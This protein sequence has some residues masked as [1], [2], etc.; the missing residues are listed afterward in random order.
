MTVAGLELTAPASGSSGEILSSDA[1][2]FVARLAAEFEP[3][4]QELLTLRRF[5]QAEIDAGRFPDFLEETAAM[6]AKDWTVA[7]IPRDLEDRRVEITGPV[8]RKMVINAL[9]SGANVFMADFEDANSPTWHNN[10][11]G[12]TQCARCRE[13]ARSNSPV[14]RASSTS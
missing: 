3:R 5:R 4:R 11:D 10:V 14:R 9:N 6:R 8:D 12:Q 13:P 7:A 2:N 1:L